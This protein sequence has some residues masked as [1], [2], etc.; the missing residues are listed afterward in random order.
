MDDLLNQ[1]LFALQLAWSR[2]EYEISGH[3][4]ISV[5]IAAILVLIW[6]FLSPQV[7]RKGS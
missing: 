5:A 7:R 4:A 1:G 2:A 6:I 3:I